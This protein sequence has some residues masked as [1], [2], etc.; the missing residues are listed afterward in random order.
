MAHAKDSFQ[1][2]S[3]SLQ[4]YLADENNLRQLTS[5]TVAQNM[6]MSSGDQINKQVQF[7]VP[8]DAT[9]TSLV[10]LVS[11]SSN[12]MY[13]NGYG[14]SYYYGYP[15]YNNYNNNYYNNNNNYYNYPNYP[16]DNYP[17]SYQSTSDNALA[18]LSYVQAPT[19]EY[20]S[21]QSQYQQL[22]Q[23]LNQTQAQNQQ[24]QQQLQTAQTAN[25]QKNST[26]ANLSSQLSS[27]QGTTTLVEVVAVILAIAAIALA[28]LH[29]KPTTT[30]TTTTRT[31][32]TESHPAAKTEEK[33]T[34]V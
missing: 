18:S 1:L 25:A 8:S 27:T 21:L 28:A 9:R 10:A 16:S 19:P 11:E 3:L 2:T 14:Y 5:A 20:V 31:T 29:F 22:Q 17:Y 33:T 26:I 6:M 4:V 12:G 13:S 7:T 34:D 24:L 32:D 30:R 23:Q 15:Y